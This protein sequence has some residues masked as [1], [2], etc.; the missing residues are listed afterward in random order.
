M[1]LTTLGGFREAKGA[2]RPIVITDK[3][4]GNKVH[5]APYCPWV[6]EAFFTSKVLTNHC[7][8]GHYYAVGTVEEGMRK[9]R[10]VRCEKCS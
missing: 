6:R 9:Y 10:A 8:N 2:N 3:E 4:N 7:E 1:E 5:T